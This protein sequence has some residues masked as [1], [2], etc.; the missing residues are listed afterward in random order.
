VATALSIV[1]L[2]AGLGLLVVA[3]D[4]FVGAAELVAVRRR[5]SPAV[6]GA[7]VVG[8]GTSLP[9]LVTSV[10]AAFAGEADLAVG[11]AAG[12]NVANLLLILGLAALVAP[13]RAGAAPPR[14]DA[15]IAATAGL[16]LLL[17]SLDGAI[18]ALDAALLLAVILGLTLWQAAAGRA[19]PTEVGVSVSGPVHL[20]LRLLGGLVG[21]LVGAQ[22]LVV[23]ATRIAEQ[24]G[25]PSIVVGAVLVAI[26]TSLPEL[27][28][29][30][31]SARRG[32][33]ELLVGNL[34]G[35]NAFNALAVVG[36]AALVTAVRGADLEV[37]ASARSVV[38]AATV[39]TL[40]VGGWLAW[41][42]QVGRWAG[43]ALVAAYLAAVPALLAIG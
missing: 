25:V 28:T 33:T 31:A 42:P 4:V 20:R 24:L 2:L 30:I 34:L 43:A 29:A 10:L 39:T 8:F 1:A 38:V 13:L 18:R 7:V 17:V 16:V 19:H 35:S 21:V 36:S 11:N 14:R 27:A 32:Q 3:A 5:W 26:G 40:V 22:L 9:E 41:R 37:A 23:G 15:S 12:S 6:I